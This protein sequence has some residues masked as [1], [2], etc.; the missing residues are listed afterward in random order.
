MDYEEDVLSV[1]NRTNFRASANLRRLHETLEKL[2]DD[3]EALQKRLSEELGASF[4][5]CLIPGAKSLNL[6]WTPG[7]SHIVHVNSRDAKTL[8][9]LESAKPISASKSTRSFQLP[10]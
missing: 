1:L 8:S 7:L 3:K 6:R 9:D 2:L 4:G 10:V 5:C